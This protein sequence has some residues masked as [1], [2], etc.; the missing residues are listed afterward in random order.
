MIITTHCNPFNECLI[1]DDK[2]KS[3][4]TPAVNAFIVDFKIA[5]DNKVTPVTKRICKTPLCDYIEK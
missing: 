1:T 2:K 3:I 4:E 5:N